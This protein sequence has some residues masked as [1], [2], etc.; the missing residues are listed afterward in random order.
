MKQVEV[1]PCFEQCLFCAQVV[2]SDRSGKSSLS[3]SLFLIVQVGVLACK[4]G[5]C[6]EYV[7]LYYKNGNSINFINKSEVIK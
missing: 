7:Y 2:K 5:T 1:N 6:M 3:L 4:R